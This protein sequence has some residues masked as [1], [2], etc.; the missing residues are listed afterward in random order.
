MVHSNLRNGLARVFDGDDR[1]AAP[2]TAKVEIPMNAM[3]A[4]SER[5]AETP[6]KDLRMALLGLIY[7]AYGGGSPNRAATRLGS[8][9][10]ETRDGPPGMV[11]QFSH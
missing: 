10:R 6:P 4:P 5:A 8:Q 11:T 1:G 3:L 7:T 2:S 9:P